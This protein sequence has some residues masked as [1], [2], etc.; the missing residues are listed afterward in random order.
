MPTNQKRNWILVLVVGVFLFFS[1]WW[2]FQNFYEP[3]RDGVSPEAFAA[4]YGLIALI[5]GCFGLYVTSRW[6]WFSSIVGKAVGF[7]SLGLLAQEFGQ[8]SYSFYSIVLG[9]EVPYP[10]IGDLGFFGSMVLYILGAYYLVR[11][12]TL[13]TSPAK[14]SFGVNKLAVVI[15]VIML[16]T[17]YLVFLQDYTFDPENALAA[18][19]DFSAP[20]LQS[21][22]L[23]LALIAF[24]YTKRMVSSLMHRKLIF[25]LFALVFQYVSDFLFLYKVQRDIYVTGGYTDLFYMI[26]YFLMAVAIIYLNFAFNSISSKRGAGISE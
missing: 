11:L 19:L 3:V 7:L 8:V 24:Y 15:P 6:G 12:S 21:V 5:G 20:L 14:L 26:S 17:V 4:T 10:S 9:V 23:S 22:Y 16:V 18:V 2:V 25:L 1:L 13:K